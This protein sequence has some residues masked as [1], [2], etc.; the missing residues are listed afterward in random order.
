M[1]RIFRFITRYFLLFGWPGARYITNVGYT[2]L[3][4]E[5]AGG[6]FFI[7]LVKC[8]LISLL[9]ELFSLYFTA[10]GHVEISG[11]WPLHT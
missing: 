2:L 7:I 10:L 1:Y 3:K 5:F 9:N 11:G 8:L 4:S 6:H